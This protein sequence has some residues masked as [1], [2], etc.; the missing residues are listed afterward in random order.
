MIAALKSEFRKLLTV[1]STYFIVLITLGIVALFAG[2]G[3]GYQ[4]DPQHLS[5]PGLLVSES[6]NGILFVGIILALV[7][8]L[9]LAHEYRYNTILYTITSSNSRAKSLLAKIIAVTVFAVIA[10]VMVTFFSPLCTIIGTHLAGKHMVAQTFPV[11]H[12]LWQCLCVGLGYAM[13][14][15]II[16]A[17]VR[18][19]VGAIVTF[20]LVPLIGEHIIMAI[21]SSSYKY[22]PFN[23]L[24]AVVN[25]DLL[26]GEATSK[27]STA[28]SVATAG[29]YI[30]VGLVVSF[31]L[32]AR[33]DAN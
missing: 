9:L 16:T 2:F 32:F 10:S 30:V 5:N 33:R 23:N 21:F 12:V 28:H 8:L 24:Q 27:I 31:I 4:A 3:N 20:L 14:A 7:G 19:Q 18:S 26:R 22:L 17:I 6:A 1:R 13:Y 11:W 15:F 29:I 25:S